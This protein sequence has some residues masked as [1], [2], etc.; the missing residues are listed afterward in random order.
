MGGDQGLDSDTSAYTT[1]EAAEF[2]YHIL[3]NDRSKPAKSDLLPSQA[4]NRRSKWLPSFTLC[5]EW[6]RRLKSQF[7]SCHGKATWLNG[8]TRA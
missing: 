3:G 2:A 6:G 5:C 7:Y 1:A 8:P 4:A